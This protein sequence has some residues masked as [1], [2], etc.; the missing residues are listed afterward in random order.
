MAID[1]LY[2]NPVT[3]YIGD[4]RDLAGSCHFAR[5]HPTVLGQH[6]WRDWFELAARI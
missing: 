2:Q 5:N 1:H 3:I 4:Q 6:E